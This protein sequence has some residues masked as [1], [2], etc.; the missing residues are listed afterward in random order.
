MRGSCAELE[1]GSSV[2]TR[3]KLQYLGIPD[4]DSH[5]YN[6]YVSVF[7]RGDKRSIGLGSPSASWTWTSLSQ[8]ELNILLGLISSGEASAVVHIKTYTDEGGGR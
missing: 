7:T 3:L 4:I 5:T 2:A 6:P 8:R 1:I